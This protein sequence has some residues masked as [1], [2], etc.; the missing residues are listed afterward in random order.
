[1]LPSTFHQGLLLDSSGPLGTLWV[2]LGLGAFY[3][4]LIWIN[5]LLGN[6]LTPLFLVP[7]TWMQDHFKGRPVGGLGSLP[8]A[9]ASSMNAMTVN[10]TTT[11]TTTTA[12]PRAPR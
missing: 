12:A 4:A 7:L 8:P 3:I 11:T 2:S 6:F 10:S 9:S 1:M 5:T